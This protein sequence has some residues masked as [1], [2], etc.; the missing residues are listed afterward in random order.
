[1]NRPT[2]RRLDPS[3]PQPPP[4]WRPRLK[5]VVG[6]QVMSIR[7]LTSAERVGP[8][9]QRLLEA[10]WG[11]LNTLESVT[12]GPAIARYHALRAGEIDLEAGFP[13]GETVPERAPI[14]R[15]ELPDCQAATLVCEGSYGRLPDAYAELEAWIAAQGLVPAGGPWEIYWVDGQQAT[16]EDDLRTEIVWPV[17]VR[18]S[19]G[20]RCR[21]SDKSGNPAGVR[22]GPG[23]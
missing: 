3:G 16:S 15:R 8:T 10:V 9:I 6:Q 20:R 1:M 4:T 7:T 19:R 18:S 12:V 14:L 17:R 23:F 13:V 11:Y 2:N 22:S 5:D 21:C